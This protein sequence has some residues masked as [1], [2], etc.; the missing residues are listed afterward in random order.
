MGRFLLLEGLF[1]APRNLV[2]N[3]LET[4][5][6][7]WRQSSAFWGDLSSSRSSLG[8]FREPLEPCWPVLGPP[9]AP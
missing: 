7:V 1:G 6:A 8:P 4:S 3:V 9:E 5:G 2:S